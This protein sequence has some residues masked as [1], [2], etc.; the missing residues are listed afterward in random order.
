MAR[1]SGLVYR[2]GGARRDTFWVPALVDSTTLASANSAAITASP[3]AA[4]LALRPFTIIRTRG[5]IYARSDQTAALE[6]WQVALGHCVV[7]DQ[8]LAIGITAVP[9]PALDM[10]S[11]LWFVY[12]E[13]MSS[14]LFVSGGGVDA[15][16]GIGRTY[17]SKG[18][19][20]VED[21]ESCIIV[22]EASGLSAGVKIVESARILIKLH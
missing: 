13:L 11:D 19:R 3:S 7:S 10:G 4:L 5:Y 9:T 8:A 14:F 22:V 18:S 6:D 20:K 17:D 1:K 16:S 21:G 12:E 2:K 15:R